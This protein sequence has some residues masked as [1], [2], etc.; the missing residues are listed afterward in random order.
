MLTPDECWDHA[1]RCLDR[2]N[3]TEMP[4]IKVYC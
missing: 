3:R 4:Q 2:A 1:K